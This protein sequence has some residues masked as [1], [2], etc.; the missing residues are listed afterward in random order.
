MNKMTSAAAVL[1]AGLF[2]AG[3]LTV[4]LGTASASDLKV[5]DRWAMGEEIDYGSNITA[6]KSQ[7]NSLLQ[8]YADLTI[9]KMK[10]NSKLSYY[11]LCEVTG[12]TATT[13][14][15]TAKTAVRFA[16]SAEI[17]VT[18]KMPVAGTYSLTDN[19]FSPSSSVAKETKTMSIDLEEK[20]GMVLTA[21]T[22]IEKSTMAI[23]NMTWSYKGALSLE[24]DAKNIPDINVSE[25]AMTIAYKDYDVGMEIVAG[26]NLYMDFAPAL[27][28][29]K[30]P[31]NQ[32]E[33]W[34]TNTS[35]VTIRGNVNG[36]L[37]AHGL[38]DDQKAL[39]FTE[40][41][42][43][44]TGSTDFPISFENINTAAGKITNGEFGPYYEDV[45]PIK[46]RCLSG[47]IEYT[48]DG[49][50]R[51]YW[52]IQVDDGPRIL[53]SPDMSVPAGMLMTTNDVE[54]PDDASYLTSFLGNQVKME[55]MD[56]E[57]VSKNIGSIEAYTDKL[58]AEVNDDGFNIRDFFFK[59]P[60]LGIFF[61]ALA[62]IAIAILAFFM[63][64][65]RKP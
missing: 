4:P 41:L 31:V 23:T 3:I 34:Y 64:R 37:D 33:V 47:N 24:A 15:I 28:L 43:N 36:H 44:A 12:E 58:T 14:T 61:T 42:R 6:S 18:G 27:D 26:L 55:P 48:V 46:M 25:D 19:I 8:N 30:L 51:S 40:E 32:G 1:V 59:A 20:M 60:F 56:M 5:G 35:T 52:Y 53:F 45:A 9:D 62:V 17:A 38:T 54:L 65:P 50:K 29:F 63:V 39:I 7:I 22:I 49:E 21:T 11:V 57:E 10:V 13:Y 2:L 16:T